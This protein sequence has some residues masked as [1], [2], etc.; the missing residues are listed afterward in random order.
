M[1]KENGNVVNY[2]FDLLFAKN[3]SAYVKTT[4]PITFLSLMRKSTMAECNAKRKM[5]Q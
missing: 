1:K 3:V 2:N 5:Q 4:I